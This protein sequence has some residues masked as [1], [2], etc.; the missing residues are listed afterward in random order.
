MC[1]RDSY[2]IDDTI[3]IKGKNSEEIEQILGYRGRTALV[4]RDDLV[5]SDTGN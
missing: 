4:H 5:I 3:S 2:S 1:I